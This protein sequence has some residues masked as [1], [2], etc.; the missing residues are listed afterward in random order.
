MGR[1][2]EYALDILEEA[3]GDRFVRSDSRLVPFGENA[4]FGE[5]DGV[6][7]ER[8]GV[9]I[10]V[11]SPKQV[12]GG[13]LDLL[14]HPSPVKLVVLVDARHRGTTR[15]L[16]QVASILAGAATPGAVVRLSGT[17]GAAPAQRRGDT[18]LLRRVVEKYIGET[19]KNLVRIFDA[20]EDGGAVLFLDEGQAM[21]GRRTTVRD[22]HDR[23]ANIETNS[24][25][26]PVDPPSSGKR[27]FDL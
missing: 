9:E 7:D 8:I 25:S 16:R 15:S 11:G 3:L 1:Y 22:A 4:G 21:F 10:G 26:A 14:W 19:E 20:A 18:Y 24:L 13:L 23:Y 2:E 17:D 27:D 12:R 5:I 6:I